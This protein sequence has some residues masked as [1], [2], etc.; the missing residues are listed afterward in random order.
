MFT[1]WRG[2]GRMVLEAVDLC[3]NALAQDPMLGPPPPP[4]SRYPHSVPGLVNSENTQRF[5]NT[6]GQG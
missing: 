6:V 4:A 2:D 1:G 5:Q 3:G